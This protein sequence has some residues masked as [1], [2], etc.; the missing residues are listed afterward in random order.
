MK[1]NTKNILKQCVIQGSVFLFIF[2]I[3]LF[4]YAKNT[5]DP[6]SGGTSGGVI[7]NP[8]NGGTNDLIGLIT[9]VLNSIIMPIAAV[10]C[11]LWIIYAGFLYVK[12]QGKPKEIGE[13][14]QTLLWALVGTG[15]L[16]G[17]AGISTVLK[18]TINSVIKTS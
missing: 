8:L 2:V 10:F 1:I 17:A 5:V 18:N 7:P 9:L 14:H 12:A 15:I 13:A 16:L 6:S 4:V 11:V 3:P